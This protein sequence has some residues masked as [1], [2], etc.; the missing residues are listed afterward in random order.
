VSAQGQDQ[1]QGL[2]RFRDALVAGECPVETY[3]SCSSLLL[4]ERIAAVGYDSTVID[5]QHGEGD[6]RDAFALIGALRAAGHTTPAVRVPWN[7]PAIIMKVLDAGAL[8]VVCPMI[9]TRAQAEAFVGACRYPPLGY[10]SFGPLRRIPAD[11]EVRTGDADVAVMAVAQIETLEAIENI[12]AIVATP[13]LSGLFPGPGDLSIA[14]GGDTGIVDY[15]D[16]RAIERLRHIIGVAHDAGIFVGLPAV[17]VEW[18][19]RLRDIGVDWIQMGID[20]MTASQAAEQM[21]VATR[22]ALDSH[23]TD[24]GAPR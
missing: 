1:G 13:G 18:I 4:A 14:T 10:R 2:N 23:T 8:G 16:P 22:A 15:E 20:W 5:L 9:D 24:T 12:E 3:L 11:R 17:R 7:D 21:L 6:Y 19:P